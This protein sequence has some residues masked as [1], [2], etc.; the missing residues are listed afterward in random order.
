MISVVANIKDLPDFDSIEVHRLTHAPSNVNNG[1]I[2][3]MPV[4]GQPPAPVKQKAL[5]SYNLGEHLE[6]AAVYPETHDLDRFS[7]TDQSLMV[8]LEKD[9]GIKKAVARI[10]TLLPGQMTMEHLDDCESNYVDQE[11]LT[12]QEIQRYRA[13]CYYVK[14][15]L[16]MLEDWKPGQ[17]I[18]FGK[19]VF[20]DWKKGDTITWD[21]INDVHS[22]FN[23]GFWARSLIRITGLSNEQD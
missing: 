20:T 2:T 18:M 3:P 22:T 19:D 10:Q 6:K 7:I 5:Q 17:G 15:F 23:T 21:W 1:V 9:L 12:E 8:K 11:D 14:R 4:G 16:I 13:D